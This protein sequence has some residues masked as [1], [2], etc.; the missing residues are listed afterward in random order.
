MRAL[1]E[2]DVVKRQQHAVPFIEQNIT[3][4]KKQKYGRQGRTSRRLEPCDETELHQEKKH[5]EE[6]SAC[7]SNNEGE[8]KT[9]KAF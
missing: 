1:K 4:R 5:D 2:R 7:S 3:S 8:R 9:E 6:L